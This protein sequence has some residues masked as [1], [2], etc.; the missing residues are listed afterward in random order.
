MSNSAI[1]LVV[2]IVVF[3][4]WMSMMGNPHVVES[5]T[6]LVLAL[7][8]GFVTWNWLRKRRDN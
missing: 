6:G 3:V 8:A 5:V 4:A 2:A 1:A 7:V